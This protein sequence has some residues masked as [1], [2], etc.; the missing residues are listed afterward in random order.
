MQ[1]RPHLND[2][3][4][5]VVKLQARPVIPFRSAVIASSFTIVFAIVSRSMGT[6]R[7][8][9]KSLLSKRAAGYLKAKGAAGDPAPAVIEG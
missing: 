2:S 5:S 3:A 4:L 1:V 7:R 9:V 6:L 8:I